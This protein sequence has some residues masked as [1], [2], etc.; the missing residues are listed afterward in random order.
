MGDVK[1]FKMA[2]PLF[3]LENFATILRQI[4]CL[5][6]SDNERERDEIKETMFFFFFFFL[7][8]CNY[9]PFLGLGLGLWLCMGFGFL[10]CDWGML[11]CGVV[12]MAWTSST[13]ANHLSLLSSDLLTETT[14]QIALPLTQG[15]KTVH[16]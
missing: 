6:R 2:H 8:L 7:I 3:A 9:Y 16:I 14:H 15:R 4:W 12:F 10:V 5:S 13:M 11:I 1:T